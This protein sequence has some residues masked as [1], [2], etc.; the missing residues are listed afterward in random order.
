MPDINALLAQIPQEKLDEMAADT[1]RIAKEDK[2]MYHPSVQD[3]EI[4]DIFAA[5]V[6]F[7]HMR[8]NPDIDIDVLATTCYEAADSI[9]EVRFYT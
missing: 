3:L 2:E 5:I 9:M 7:S 1:A 4:R 6:L 8:K